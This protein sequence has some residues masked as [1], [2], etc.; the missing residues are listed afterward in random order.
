[1]KIHLTGHIDVPPDRLE[2]VTKALAEHI[3][4]TRAEA[5]CELFEVRPVPG[6]PG[7]FSVE[8]VFRSRTDFEAHQERAAAS[9]WA[10]ASAGL[11]RHYRIEEITP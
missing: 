8:E 9:Y 6:T 4:L 2:A 3:R 10:R 11:A 1:M 7:R 5:G